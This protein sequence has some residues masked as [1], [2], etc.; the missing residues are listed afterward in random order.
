M[1]AASQIILTPKKSSGY[2]Y[3]V[4]SVNGNDGNSGRTAAKAFQNL[5][6]LPTLLTGQSVGLAR[7]SVW[8]SRM[9]ASGVA[10]ASSTM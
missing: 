4:D 5:T 9:S 8:K 1:R 6:A 2:T 10:C 3:Y 7:N